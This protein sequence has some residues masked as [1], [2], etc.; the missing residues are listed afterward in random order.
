M[1]ELVDQLAKAGYLERRPD[2]RDGRAKLIYLTRKGRRV[3]AQAVRAVRDIE[4]D[5]AATVGAVRFE[6]MCRS[7]QAVLDGQSSESEG[8][9]VAAAGRNMRPRSGAAASSRRVQRR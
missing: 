3:M 6:K 2:P 8:T 5:Y 7:L 1:V 9:A 4:R